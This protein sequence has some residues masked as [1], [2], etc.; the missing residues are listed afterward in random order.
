MVQNLSCACHLHCFGAGKGSEFHSG[1]LSLHCRP[2]KSGGG[3]M[4]LS[5]SEATGGS[6]ELIPFLHCSWDNSLIENE[7]G[8]MFSKA[9]MSAFPEWEMGHSQ[10]PNV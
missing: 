8:T 4:G 2:L 7:D 3:D 6:S 10:H 1:V 9:S 5:F